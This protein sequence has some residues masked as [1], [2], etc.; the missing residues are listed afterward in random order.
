M[1]SLFPIINDLN[2]NRASGYRPMPIKDITS[3]GTSTFAMGRRVFARSY[4]ANPSTETRPPVNGIEGYLSK[5]RI[6]PTVFD[7]THTAIQKKWIG[8]TR[9][10]SQ[11][12]STLTSTTVGASLNQSQGPVSFT[13]YTETNTV[14]NAKI[15]MRSGGAVS[16]IKCNFRFVK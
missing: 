10:S 6:L 5:N 7:S 12:T 15:R 13:S 16:P 1:I 14:R 8:G 11:R 9:D 4:A 2:N 3:D